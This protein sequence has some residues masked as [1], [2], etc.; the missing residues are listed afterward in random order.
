MIPRN[1]P[2]PTLTTRND[3]RRQ[4]IQLADFGQKRR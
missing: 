4:M 3:Q 1:A 2:L